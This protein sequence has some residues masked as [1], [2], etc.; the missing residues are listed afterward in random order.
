MAGSTP[1]APPS[2]SHM[3]WEAE[4][5]TCEDATFSYSNPCSRYMSSMA[6]SVILRA[7]SCL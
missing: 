4:N 3:R 2:D 7:K 5:R 1:S 6:D